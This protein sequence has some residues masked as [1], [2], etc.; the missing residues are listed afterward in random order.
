MHG[1]AAREK[2]WR[3]RRL[4]NVANVSVPWKGC[5][6][7]VIVGCAEGTESS[8][9]AKSLYD[10]LGV[11]KPLRPWWISSSRTWWPAPGSTDGL[12]RPAFQGVSVISSIKSVCPL[13]G[14][15]PIKAG[16]ENH[17]RRLRRAGGRSG[18]PLNKFN[19]PKRKQQELLALL[20]PMKK[21][22][23]EVP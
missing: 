18:Q 13:V 7:Q 11:R 3:R 10:R 19:V 14:L 15:V 21:D 12:P 1:F 16:H 4:K 22:I 5:L 23:V 17:Q 8:R 9:A 6:N 2:F 20:G